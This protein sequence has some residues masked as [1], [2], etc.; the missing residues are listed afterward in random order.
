[1][2]EQVRKAWLSALSQAAREHVVVFTTAPVADIVRDTG[3]IRWLLD[4]GYALV[5]PDEKK[6]STQ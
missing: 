2:D 6:P 1:L 3:R 5:N 4:A